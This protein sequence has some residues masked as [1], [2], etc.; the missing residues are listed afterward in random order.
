MGNNLENS[1]ASIIYV[2]F[3]YQWSLRPD[4][5]LCAQ[6]LYYFDSKNPVVIAMAV[7]NRQKSFV[8]E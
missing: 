3:T 1:Y 5:I 6:K 2:S 8:N 4:V 7:L